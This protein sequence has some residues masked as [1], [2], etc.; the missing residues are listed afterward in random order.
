[1]EKQA[2]SI[3]VLL[4]MLLLAGGGSLI[5]NQLSGGKLARKAKALINPEAVREEQITSA[6]KALEGSSNELQSALS[7][8][9]K[10][11]QHLTDEAKSQAGLQEL[12]NNVRNAELAIGL[13]SVVPSM[14]DRR[15]LSPL[16][17][18]THR[19]ASGAGGLLGAVTGF[20]AG[21]Q[22]AKQYSFEKGQI[23]SYKQIWTSNKLSLPEK[24]LGH[25]GKGYAEVISFLPKKY[26]ENIVGTA[27]A[28][29]HTYAMAVAPFANFARNAPAF[30]MRSP[31][32]W[33]PQIKN[34]AGTT[35]PSLATYAQGDINNQVRLENFQREFDT[36]SQKT[37]EL[38]ERANRAAQNME[39]AMQQL[40]TLQTQ[41]K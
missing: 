12:S 39:T 23:P 31:S 28:I 8:Y 9:E 32:T 36:A 35:A 22:L 30:A 17:T 37:T 38:A 19:A 40:N 4:A 29:P 25:Y 10:V 21:K 11:Q 5:A 20:D 33:L 7:D 2:S 18:W 14:L 41:T 24:V 3:E 26:R 34:I 1:M 16:T 6:R 15:R 27:A 13:G